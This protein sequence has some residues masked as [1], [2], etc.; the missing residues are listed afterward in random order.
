MAEVEEKV[1]ALLGVGA[2]GGEAIVGD[3]EATEE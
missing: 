3:A 1:K 2:R